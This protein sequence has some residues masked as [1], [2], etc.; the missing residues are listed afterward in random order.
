MPRILDAG[1]NY[2]YIDDRAIAQVGV[3]Y[4]ILILP[5]VERIPLAT[6]RK[7][8]EYARKGGILVATRRMPSIAPGDQQ[9]RGSCSPNITSSTRVPGFTNSSSA[10]MHNCVVS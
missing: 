2:D 8:E 6:Y 5:G 4:P 1:Y 3:P 9:M 7:L 10:S